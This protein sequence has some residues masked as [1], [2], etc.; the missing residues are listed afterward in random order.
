MVET[1]IESLKCGGTSTQKDALGFPTQFKVE[2][3]AWRCTATRNTAGTFSLRLLQR[4]HRSRHQ[5]LYLLLPTLTNA[6]FKDFTQGL[7]K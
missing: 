6:L 1:F 2:P 7:S 3:D 5:P 4:L